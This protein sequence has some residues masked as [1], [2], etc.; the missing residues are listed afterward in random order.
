VPVLGRMPLD[1]ALA[2]VVEKEAFY[3]AENPY[4]EVEAL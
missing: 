1:A 3:E 4:L 2:E